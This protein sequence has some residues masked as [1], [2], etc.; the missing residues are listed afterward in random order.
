MIETERQ[1]ERGVER[2]FRHR[3]QHPDHRLQQ[4]GNRTASSRQDADADAHHQSN[5]EPC[6]QPEQGDPR[7]CE[8]RAIAEQG[9]KTAKHR[10]GGRQ[11]RR[12]R[13]PKRAHRVPERQHREDR[14]RAD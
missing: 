13:K 6:E 14:Q 10:V 9:E 7:V 4:A 11:Q 2:D 5:A 8:E 1:Y 12:R 3:R